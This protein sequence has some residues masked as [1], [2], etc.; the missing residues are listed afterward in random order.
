MTSLNTTLSPGTNGA[1]TTE[2]TLP[3]NGMTCASCVR[4]VEK[5]LGKATGVASAN[6]NLA[7]ERATVSYDPAVANLDTLRAAVE[8]AGY[9]VGTVSVPTLPVPQPITGEVMLPIEG[10]T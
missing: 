4:R 10:M 6:V 9:G 5:A 3:I 1:T 2:V 8:K 7:T